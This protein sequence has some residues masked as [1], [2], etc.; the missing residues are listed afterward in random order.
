MDSAASPPDAAR[1]DTG[2][3]GLFHRLD[4]RARPPVRIEVDGR[5]VTALRG[6]TVLV[7]L[8][9][10]GAR[11]RENEFDGGP[12]AGFCLMGACQE[13]WVWTVEGGRLRS[14]STEVAEGMRLVT[15]GLP[16]G[17]AW[18]NPAS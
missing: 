10:H 15:T 5:M 8:L 1:M 6:D 9:T 16:G 17:M 2:E 13:C 12:R 4:E 3:N 7:A 14:C 11:L 18:P